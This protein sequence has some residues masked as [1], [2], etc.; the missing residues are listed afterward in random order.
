MGMY[1]SF[2][3]RCHLKADTPSSVI[4]VLDYLVAHRHN[5]VP[6]ELFEAESRRCPASAS[7]LKANSV[8][9]IGRPVF[10]ADRTICDATANGKKPWSLSKSPE[11]GCEVFIGTN[12][13]NYDRI[14]QKFWDWISPWIVESVG[15]VVGECRYEEYDLPSPV[16]VGGEL[17][18]GQWAP[19]DRGWW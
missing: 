15:T 11:G 7:F 1:T 5:D 9:S 19:N 13:T 16:V 6:T 17:K 4:D 10:D 8:T 3:I 18:T 14:L 2:W 12:V